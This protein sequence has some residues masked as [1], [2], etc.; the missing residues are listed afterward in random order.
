MLQKLSSPRRPA[1]ANPQFIHSFKAF[2]LLLHFHET[3]RCAAER[4]SRQ[5]KEQSNGNGT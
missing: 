5:F 3:L 4:A 1:N 2:R